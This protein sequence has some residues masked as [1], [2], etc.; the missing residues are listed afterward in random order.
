MIY[1]FL[2]SLVFLFFS[3]QSILQQRWE[4][5][6]SRDDYILLKKPLNPSPTETSKQ[7]LDQDYLINFFSNFYT[8]GK[9]FSDNRRFFS[10]EFLKGLIPLFPIQDIYNYEYL[11]IWKIEDPVFPATRLER[12]IVYIQFHEKFVDMY[13]K[14][15]N[16]THVHLTPYTD[17]E[18]QD[19]N[20]T[21][22]QCSSRQEIWWAEDENRSL[23]ILEDSNCVTDSN[24][25]GQNYRRI[26]I[27]NDPKRSKSGSPKTTEERLE[28]LNKLLRKKL[29]TPEEYKK[30]RKG[31][32][33]EI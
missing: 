31:I 3:C 21:R 33:S 1:K 23:D 9:L 5:L 13:W 24:Q 16:Q 29:I 19:F 10:S 28:E 14:E 30:L 25:K 6:G 8:K 20:S 7:K 27:W 4:R 2:F 11:L 22:H 12:V 26:R 17:R 15:I 18:W 32:L